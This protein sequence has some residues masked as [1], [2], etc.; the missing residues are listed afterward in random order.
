MFN[1]AEISEKFF[2]PYKYSLDF[3]YINICAT[4]QKPQN[5]NIHYFQGV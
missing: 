3:G 4:K 2:F 1:D 5:N